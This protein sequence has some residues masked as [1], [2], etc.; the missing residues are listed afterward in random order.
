M[1]SIVLLHV[2]QQLAAQNSWRLSALHVHHGISPRADEWVALCADLCTQLH[3]PLHIKHV[4]I[5]PLRA[6]GIEAAARK[7][8][9]AAL[10]SQA[11]DFV[12][13]A[14]HQDD[15]V[16]TLLLQLLRGAGVKGAAAM[17]ALSH[18]QP[19][20]IRPLL[21]VARTELLAYAQQHALRWVEDESNRDDTYPRNFLRQQVLPVVEQRFPAYRSTL[22][23]SARH[24]AEASAL[25][26]QL[27]RLDAR[28]AMHGDGLEVARLRALD[29]LRGKNLLRY[30]FVCRG[31]QLPDATRLPEMLRQLCAARD[32]AALRITFGSWELRR[33]QGRAYALPLLPQT[34]AGFC[35]AWNGEDALA[36]PQLGGTLHFAP[37]MGQGVDRGKMDRAMLSVRLRQG[38]ER[39]RAGL[40]RPTR[41]LSNLLQEHA[42]PPWQRERLPLLFCGDELVAVP[43]VAVASAWQA[44]PHEAGVNLAWQVWRLQTRAAQGE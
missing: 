40:G 20:L 24:F 4:D 39:I 14:H 32:D 35:V 9:H 1:D 34:A 31:A 17:P 41:S 7:L 38:A 2:L 12:A 27:A 18:T 16:E 5:T 26:D 8:R 6:L 25:L 15:Q 30:F 3:I 11:V 29:P 44:A 22:T 19:V 13:L 43:G 36:L 37:C 28:G 42:M 10:A 23:R 21:D 33:Y